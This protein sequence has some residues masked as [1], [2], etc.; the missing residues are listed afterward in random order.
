MTLPTPRTDSW[1]LVTGASSGIGLELAR[2]LAE[3]RHNLILVA[4]R[5]DRLKSLALD[6]R[7][8]GVAA[9]PFQ[10]DLADP[11]RRADLLEHLRDK[12]ISVLCNNAGFANF[13]NVA[14]V[15][16]CAELRQIELNVTALAELTYA[17]VPAMVS[18][19][20]GA[21]L[22]VGSTAGY[23]PVPGNATYSASKAFVHSFAQ[24]LHTELHG[25]G[26]SCTLVTPGPVATEFNET[27]GIVGGSDA[28][29]ERISM[30]PRQVAD[31]ALR[32]LGNHR[33]ICVPGT[34][35]KVQVVGSAL[36]PTPIMLPMLRRFT[37]GLQAG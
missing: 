25:T 31:T 3:R 10:C 17:L 6:L 24:S 32:A 8:A 4:R 28:L 27:A 16:P 14:T 1:A 29:L 19:G 20:S 12:K 22:M 5:L 7:I 23:Q 26:V 33:R 18:R 2:G 34:V 15:D 37:A 30:T 13:G 9:E 21:I 36:T 35:A 11:S